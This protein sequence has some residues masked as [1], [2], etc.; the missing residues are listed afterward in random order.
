MTCRHIGERQPVCSVC[1]SVKN[2]WYERTLI[3]ASVIRGHHDPIDIPMSDKRNQRDRRRRQDADDYDPSY[4]MPEFR[5]RSSPVNTTRLGTLQ[6]SVWRLWCAP[7][8]GQSQRRLRRSCMGRECMNPSEPAKSTPSVAANWA[9]ADV[10]SNAA[11]SLQFI[12]FAISNDQYGVDILAVRE[13]KGWSKIALL[14][15]QPD[16][17]R[18]DQFNE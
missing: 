12:S 16:Y 9:T 17:V 2:C 10:G 15:K 7:V 5:A 11:R 4:T 13:I 6:Q 1:A 18:G 14:P 3:L 8:C